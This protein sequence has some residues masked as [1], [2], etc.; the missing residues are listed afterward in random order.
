MILSAPTGGPATS[1]R[2]LL[3]ASLLVAAS[4]AIA[5]ATISQ[6]RTSTDFR[7][8]SQLLLAGLTPRVAEARQAVGAN[9][10]VIHRLRPM[11]VTFSRRIVDSAAHS[12]TDWGAL[13]VRVSA[14]S[15]SHSWLVISAWRGLDRVT[16]M[17]NARVWAE[18]LTVADSSLMPMRRIVHVAPY[19]RW[20]GI[21]I[22]Q[23]FR[24]DSVVGRMSLDQDPTRRQ[25]AGDLRAVRGR[26]IASDPLAPFWL[27]GAAL[28]PGTAIDATI[29]GWSVVPNKD[30]TPVRLAVIGSERIVTPAG[31]FDCWKMTITVGK[32]THYHWARKTD[33]LGVLTRRRLSDGTVREVILTREGSDR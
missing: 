29:L 5:V 27:M 26:L 21:Q 15:A 9:A 2:K 10:I 6:L 24:G 17:E 4:I 32:E 3:R 20:A 11:A 7:G 8:G 13:D 30:L 23:L 16:D 31:T 22:D 33:H 18:T 19:R 14:D 25:V 12:I 28:A 1:P